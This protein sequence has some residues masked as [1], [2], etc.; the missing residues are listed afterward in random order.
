M[1]IYFTTII[2]IL[3]FLTKA[4]NKYSSYSSKVSLCKNHLIFFK[5]V[6]C[7]NI[8]LIELEEI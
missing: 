1:F 6:L 2:E 3:I 8:K 4:L 5:N 7:Q